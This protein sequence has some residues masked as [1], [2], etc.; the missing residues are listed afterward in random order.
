MFQEIIRAFSRVFWL[1]LK[2]SFVV[3]LPVAALLGVI[4]FLGDRN[5]AGEVK[6]FLPRQTAQ[7]SGIESSVQSVKS[8]WKGAQSESIDD[9]TDE[10]FKQILGEDEIQP[11]KIRSEEA[12][13]RREDL[14][15]RFEQMAPRS[16]K[17]GYRDIVDAAER[18]DAAGLTEFLKVGFDPNAKDP[19][20]MRALEVAAMAGNIQIAQVL[21]S[22]GADPNARGL[23]GTT[24][25]MLAAGRGH[26]EMVKLLLENGADVHAKND[27]GSTALTN[28]NLKGYTEIV[29]L[30]KQ[31][32]AKE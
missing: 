17:K 8:L 14:R 21:L 18:G 32:G 27:I 24:P 30:L 1:Y 5:L 29:E 11:S 26:V 6:A 22:H 23:I 4:F 2:L 12:R 9:R 19:L 13:E 20:G 15:R 28:A 25:L 10:L 16:T 31:A 7:I 3:L